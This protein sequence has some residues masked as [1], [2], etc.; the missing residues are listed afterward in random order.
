MRKTFVEIMVGL[1]V[2]LG[3]VCIGYLTIRLGKMEF[4]SSD[5]YVLK[6]KFNSVAGLK[7]GAPVNMA[8]ISVGRVTRLF[9]DLQ[10]QMAVVEM[11]LDKTITLGDDVI[12]SIKSSGL[13]GDK[14]IQ[15]TPGG[16]DSILKPGDTITETESAV[17]LESLISK[18]VFGSVKQ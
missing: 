3:C 2:I 12:A 14:H 15:L 9:V 1:F 5:E 6:A 8:G 10:L 4:F 16:S 13:I 18:F 11:K 17:D 7:K